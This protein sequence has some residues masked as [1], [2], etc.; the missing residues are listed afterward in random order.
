VSPL[1]VVAMTKRLERMV[2]AAR[3]DLAA[4]VSPLPISNLV[5]TV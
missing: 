3:E 4:P 5:L 2:E 1:L